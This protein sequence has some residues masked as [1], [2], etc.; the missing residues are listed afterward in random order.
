MIVNTVG[1][2]RNWEHYNTV[3]QVEAQI[4]YLFIIIIII[5]VNEY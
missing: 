1:R 3:Q 4:I 2:M 5:I